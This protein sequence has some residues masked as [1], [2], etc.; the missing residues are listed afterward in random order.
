MKNNLTQGKNCQISSNFIFTGEVILGNNVRIDDN[1]EFKCNYIHIDDNTHV[2]N[3]VN[4]KGGSFLIG[5]NCKIKPFARFNVK[6]RFE[7][8][9]NS[10]I[11]CYWNISG[12]NIRIGENLWCVDG[13]YF[14]NGIIG[15]GSCFDVH[16]KLEIGNN[17]HLGLY[18]YINTAR[19]VII[20]NNV[21]FG[22]RSIIWTH[23][24]WQN[25]LEGYSAS[26]APVTIGDN[27]W[28]P[29]NIQIMPGV[30]IGEGSTIG[31]GSI[32]TKDVP[33]FCLAVGIPAKII[34][35]E[36]K[37]PRKLNIEEKNRIILD[38]LNTWKPFIEDAGFKLIESTN[39]ERSVL[40]KFD[41]NSEIY[42]L[43]YFV[44][45]TD[46]P[47]MINDKNTIILTF[48]NNFSND[49]ADQIFNLQ[50]YQ[51]FKKKDNELGSH[52]QNFM[53]RRGIKFFDEKKSS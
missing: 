6:K 52:I 11:G 3:D 17:C 16:S 36:K 51:F 25:V 5:S 19:P 40:M 4:I 7:I 31:S 47:K 29:T 10:K 9:P 44:D 26:F 41:Y 20:G 2:F 43:I 14:G 35:D 21:G 34:L 12:R 30:S 38:I 48:D 22:F 13:D 49:N 8:G 50:S 37:W 53:R 27:A 39:L 24:A 45:N 15:G 1:V 18:T 42:Q 32:V 33:N 23:G 46:E 28:I